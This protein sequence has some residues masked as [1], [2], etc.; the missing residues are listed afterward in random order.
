MVEELLRSRPRASELTW[1]SDKCLSEREE[2]HLTPT[3]YR[4]LT[5]LVKHAG[6][7][8]THRQLLEEVRGPHRVNETQYLHVFM[9]Q[10]RQKI[11]K[12]PARP[13]F[14]LTEPG[15]GYRLMAENTEELQSR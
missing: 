11:E 10:L 6:K 14:L 1:R 13:R 12:D 2:V 5:T 3:E 7:V 9:N 4:L 15:V 8:L